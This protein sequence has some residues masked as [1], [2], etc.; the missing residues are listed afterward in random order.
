[1]NSTIKPKKKHLSCGHYDYNFSKGRC[2]SC[3]S[4]NY[5]PIKRVS[6][7]RM[8]EEFSNDNRSSLIADLDRIVSLYVRIKDADPKGYNDCFTCNDR[9]HYK[10]LTNGHFIQRSESG[11][12]FDVIHNCR[13]Q[14]YKC[15]NLHETN[16]KPFA[17]KL[18]SEQAGIVDYLI[19]QSRQITKLSISD[20]K[21]L[22]IAMQEKL[23]IALS[24]LK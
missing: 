16:T 24:K 5:T 13:P 20:L 15:N 3:A 18:E 17:D 23:R 2:K 19:E 10:Q 14:C 6:D 7:K 12:R 9:L 8:E 4:L 21:E 1:M 11:L 22:R